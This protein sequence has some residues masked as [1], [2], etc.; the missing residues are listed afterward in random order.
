MA[1]GPED[2]PAA[3][4]SGGVEERWL[5]CKH[6]RA[7]R[8]AAVGDCLLGGGDFFECAAEM[9]GDGAP[10]RGRAPGNRIGEC[11]VDF[12]GAGPRPEISQ[13]E[14]MAEG[15]LVA[16]ESDE[17]TRR[18]I[19]QDECAAADEFAEGLR[20]D[21]M[22][23]MQRAAE[24]FQITGECMRDGA[25]SAAG[26]GPADCVQRGREHDTDAGG[27]R[28]AETARV[29]W[30]V[31]RLRASDCAEARPEMPKVAMRSGWRGRRSGGAKRSAANCSQWRAS[32]STRLR[33]AFASGPRTA[34]L[35]LKSR[36]MTTA[37]PS[38]SGCAS[39]ASP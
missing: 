14:A 31:K 13:G 15:Q 1:V 28:P 2:M 25:R 8:L 6:K 3:G 10:A 37:S 11:V 19:A 26:N 34:S 18:D 16:G 35:V 7:L 21:A 12:E 4:R 36:S 9:D 5:G 23:R 29:R 27:E 38:S 33:Q 32:G 30:P 24:R 22:A 20:I 39:G 17:L